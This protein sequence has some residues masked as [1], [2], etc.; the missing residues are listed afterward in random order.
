MAQW[1]LNTNGNIVHQQSHPPTKTEE[2]HSEQEQMKRKIFD[3]LIVRIWGKPINLPSIEG[4]EVSDTRENQ[5]KEYEDEDEEAR[6][7]PDIEDMVYAEGSLLNHMLAYD[8]ILN[9]EVS[10][11]IREETAIGKVIQHAL[12]TDRTLAGT[13][14]ENPF[15][16][17]TIYEVEFPNGE[18][19]EYAAKIIA[20]NM[21]TQVDSYGFYLTMMKGIIDYK[22]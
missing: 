14:Y 13:Y 5:F 6:N 18:V 8:R 16:N 9:Y 12:V 19:K 15:L 3:E 10:L 22:R 20:N 21:L 1:I 11:Q 4:I 7:I 17:T 2:V